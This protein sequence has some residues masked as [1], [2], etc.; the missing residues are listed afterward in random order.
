[1]LGRPLA[2]GWVTLGLAA[3]LLALFDAP[4]AAFWPVLGA[5]LLLFA[6]WWLWRRGTRAVSRKVFGDPA[7]KEHDD[8]DRDPGHFRRLARTLGWL[9]QTK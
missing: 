5:A 2:L 3:L 6:L 8:I 7:A 1:M 9:F 4:R